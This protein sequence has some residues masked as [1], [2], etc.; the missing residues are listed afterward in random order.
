MGCTQR[1]P[2]PVMHSVENWNFIY[3]VQVSY[4]RSRFSAKF[5]W[6]ISFFISFERD[7]FS[8]E[9]DKKRKFSLKF[10]TKTASY[11]WA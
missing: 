1:A 5:M 7:I 8:L 10:G 6:K 9:R 3:G 11:I 2:K 4:V